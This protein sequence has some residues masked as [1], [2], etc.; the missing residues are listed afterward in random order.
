[1]ILNQKQG[2][3]CTSSYWQSFW[4]HVG[5]FDKLGMME[6]LKSAY[7]L[8]VA[9]PATSTSAVIDRRYITD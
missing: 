1:M 3:L 2:I 9:K 5:S 4:N 7:A 6:F 8:A